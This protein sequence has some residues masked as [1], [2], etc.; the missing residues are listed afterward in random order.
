MAI[1]FNEKVKINGNPIPVE[2]YVASGF[3]ERLKGLLLTESL[4]PKQGMYIKPCSE[5]HSFGMAYALDIVFLD[6]KS[7]V[8]KLVGLPKRSVRR[9]RSAAAVIELS[10]GNIEKLG[11]KI[12]DQLSFCSELEIEGVLS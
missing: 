10:E 8:I 5:V 7:N 9:C 4:S 6:K 12:G 1:E 2:L 3:F 11:I